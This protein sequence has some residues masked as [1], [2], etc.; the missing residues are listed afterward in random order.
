M[1]EV[2][3]Q[4]NENNTWV[5]EPLPDKAKPVQKKSAYATKKDA[6]QRATRQRAR[7]VAKGFTEKLGVDSNETFAPVAK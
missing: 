1:Q 4:L 6:Q 3:D 7:L 5:F 2:I